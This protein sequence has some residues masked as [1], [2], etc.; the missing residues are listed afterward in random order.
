MIRSGLFL[1]AAAL[2]LA[3]APASADEGMWTFDDFPAAKMKAEYGWAP[4]QAWLNR[5]QNAAVRLTGGCSAS[6]VSPAGP[7]PDQPSLRRELPVR[8]FERQQRLP[9]QA[10]SSPRAAISN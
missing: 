4:D 9:Q 2:A 3:A 8:Q 7:D 6:F 10:A 1:S 5:V